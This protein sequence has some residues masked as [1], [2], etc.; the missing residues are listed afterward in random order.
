MDCVLSLRDIAWELMH[1]AAPSTSLPIEVWKARCK[2]LLALL[3]YHP[4]Q[5]PLRSCHG[6]PEA[7]CSR[8]GLRTARRGPKS[9]YGLTKNG[10]DLWG[11]SIATGSPFA[12]SEPR[13]E[14]DCH[15]PADHLDLARTSQAATWRSYTQHDQRRSASHVTITLRPP[16][17]SV[18]RTDNVPPPQ[19]LH[20]I[21]YLSSGFTDEHGPGVNSSCKLVRLAPYQN[22]LKLLSPSVAFW[23]PSGVRY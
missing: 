23:N 20:M 5:C 7:R 1:P 16:L 10:Q 6:H 18:A 14:K 13:L 15:S 9:L 8:R 19:I 22:P 12:R 21:S 11:R 17:T 4:R 2:I 3:L